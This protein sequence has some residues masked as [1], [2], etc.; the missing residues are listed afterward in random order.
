MS[1]ETA[2]RLEE[3]E[4]EALVDRMM[5]I[6]DREGNP[7]GVEIA[8]FGGGTAVYSRTMPW[9][10]FNF[11]KGLGPQDADRI[12][13]IARFYRERGRKFEVHLVPG[14]LN[15][16]L[17]KALAAHGFMQTGFHATMVADL[18]VAAGRWKET[19][20]SAGIG[21]R[22]I[23]RD[24]FAAYGRIHCLGFGMPV[25]GAV[26]IARNNEVLHGRPGW[27]LYFGLTD[28][29]PAAAGVMRMHDGIASLTFAAT[30][31]EYRGRGLQSG[32]IRLRLRTAAEH[33]CRL[34]TAQAAFGS[35]S[36]RNMEKAGMRL[37]FTRATWSVP[38]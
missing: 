19:P 27:K 28:G 23:G 6:R 32:L 24:E 10:G 9:P 17:A 35:P 25:E 5:A 21:F 14:K 31:P 34:A 12:D 30:L 29:M 2:A 38:D 8:A 3:A 16:A 11:V 15:A 26:P 20:T 36:H 37:A 1:L 33:G 4:I 13:D 7:E 18:E 22:E